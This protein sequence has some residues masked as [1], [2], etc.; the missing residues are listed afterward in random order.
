M[1]VTNFKRIKKINF[2]RQLDRWNENSGIIKWTFE[3]LIHNFNDFQFQENIQSR[4]KFNSKYTIPLVHLYRI[5]PRENRP[6][7]YF[8]FYFINKLVIITDN[9]NTMFSTYN[10][11]K[12]VEILQKLQM[13]TQE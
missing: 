7:I 3:I 9:F 6:Q 8:I 11:N 2:V 1:I 5:V 4:G 13:T 10:S 12:F